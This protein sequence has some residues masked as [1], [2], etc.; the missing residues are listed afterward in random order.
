MKQQLLKR[1]A[2]EIIFSNRDLELKKDKYGIGLSAHRQ[3]SASQREESTSLT[4]TRKLSEDLIGNGEGMTDA[5]TSSS[6]STGFTSKAVSEI[7]N[8][9]DHTYIMDKLNNKDL[10]NNL[11]ITR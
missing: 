11:I 7:G 3:V 10:Y 9:S 6:K 2:E 8:Y 4:L 5:S 1:A